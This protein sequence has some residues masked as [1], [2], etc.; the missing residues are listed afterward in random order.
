METGIC[1]RCA[2][3][4]IVSRTKPMLVTCALI[5]KA[6]QILITQRSETMSHPLQWEFPGGKVEPGESYEDC[7]LREIQ[8]ELLVEIQ[9]LDQLPIC[10]FKY[11]G[12][13]ISL[14]PFLAQIKHGKPTLT[15]H[16][17]MAW[18]DSG[19]I[20]TYDLALADQE[21]WNGYL[22]YLNGPVK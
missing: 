11:P 10:H 7:I 13:N 18:V 12:R 9:L 22:T 14:I 1:L 8:E 16:A 19:S 3:A 21:V 2:T 15:E 5:Q 20:H 4:S 6:D 17:A